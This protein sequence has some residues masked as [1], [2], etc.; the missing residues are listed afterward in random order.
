MTHTRHALHGACRPLLAVALV[1]GLAWTPL[2]VA[3]SAGGP[4]GPAGQ[5]GPPPAGTPAPAGSAPDGGAPAPSR[6]D[7]SRPPPTIP[8]AAPGETPSQPIQGQGT[9]KG[10]SANPAPDGRIPGGKAGSGGH[11]TNE[12]GR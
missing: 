5:G 3:Q 12:Y 8:Q 6:G 4:A 2:T 11:K 9:V 10:S 1:A 7:P